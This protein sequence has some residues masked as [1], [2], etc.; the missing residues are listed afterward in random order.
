[1]LSLPAAAL[2][3]IQQAPKSASHRKYAWLFVVSAGFL[4][5]A[6]TPAS[7]AL[8]ITCLKII[9][10]RV[11]A[12][13]GNTAFEGEIGGLEWRDVG[14]SRVGRRWYQECPD[15]YNY[16]SVIESR[17]WQDPS[18]T[19]VYYRIIPDRSIERSM[20]EAKPGKQIFI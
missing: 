15:T 20:D 17:V 13:S 16:K 3:W 7:P 12:I 8:G 6:N 10:G 9:D 4:T 14:L 19:S 2:L 11:Y 5:I 1:M 18:N